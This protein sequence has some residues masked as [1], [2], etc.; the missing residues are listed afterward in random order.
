[1]REI[2]QLMPW[3]WG[4]GAA[5]K[6]QAAMGSAAA[7]GGEVLQLPSELLAG[8]TVI[9]ACT[10]L[11]FAGR[12]GWAFWKT[13]TIQRLAKR[14]ML[15]NEIERSWNRYSHAFSIDA[16]QLATSSEVSGPVTV[17]IR[18][19]MLL[20]PPNFLDSVC[21]GDLDAMFAHEF[22]HVRRHDFAKNLLYELWSLPVAYHPLLRLTRS[23]IAE[24]REM[25]CDAMAADTVAGRES[26]ARSLLRLASRIANPTPVKTLHAIGIFDANIFERRVMNLTRSYIEIRGIRRF[27][28]AATCAAVALATCG[29]ALALRMEVATPAAS[30]PA[31]A[32]SPAPLKVSAGIMSGQKISGVNPVYPPQAKADKVG[33]AVV[34][35]LTINEEGAPVDIR[36]KKS[37]RDDLDQS[38]LAAVRQWRWKPYLLNGNPTAVDTTVTVTYSLR[39]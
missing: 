37:V 36:V 11:Y 13:K 31:Q 7:S 28:V 1:M 29:T 9:Y 27:A 12:F 19:G 18:R 10:L 5:A 35:A 26:Y 15:A 32:E 34:L 23:R 14:V 20:V 33:G 38:A 39:P 2:S 8:L 30:S 16:P 22:A 6:V 4:G 21:V 3:G 17:G 25:V 24:T